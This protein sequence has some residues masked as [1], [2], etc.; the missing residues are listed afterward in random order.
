[1]SAV[2]SA[3]ASAVPSMV[4]EGAGNADARAI[5]W[6]ESLVFAA[7]LAALAALELVLLRAGAALSRPLWL[8]EIHTYL[9]AT[10]QTVIES[11]R[12]LAAGADY[13]PP[14]LY[15]LYR[16]VAMMA[17]GLTEVTMRLVALVSVL[18]ALGVTYGLLRTEYRRMPAVLAIVATWAHPVVVNVAFDARFYGPWLFGAAWLVVEAYRRLESTRSTDWWGA[19]R[20]AV[21]S[22]F[23]CTIHYFGVLSWGAVMIVAVTRG[24]FRRAL[25]AMAPAIAGPIALA[26]CLPLY[27]GQRGVLTVPTWIPDPSVG[28]VLFLL[29]VVLL[30]VATI[31]ALS[32][33]GLNVALL[34]ITK[35]RERGH[36]RWAAGLAS[37]L[38]MG[39]VI[40]P[41]TLAVFSLV[42]Q[43]AT[44]PRY[45]IVAALAVAPLLARAF[46][47]AGALAPLAGF[48][49][50]V[51]SV[52]AMKSEGD[53]AR[54]RAQVVAEDIEQIDRLTEPGS[55]IVTRRRH[56]LY[57]L[58]RARPALAARLAYLDATP[59]YP[60][61]RFAIVERDAARAH[62]RIY[63]F[64]RIESSVDLAA[65][66]AFYLIELDPSQ[67][68]T[69]SEFP[70]DSI[71]R[72][73]HRLFRL[74]RR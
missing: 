52:S 57:P 44:Q 60:G 53:V 35:K 12:S 50:L 27:R 32:A 65:R 14:A 42:V 71:A 34:R 30:P 58:L 2:E 72:V 17:G 48:A 55:L 51:C 64:P 59:A 29:G 66:D 69:P 67:A 49:A 19:A 4:R 31:I 5:P 18:A 26:C 7:G 28:D 9:L 3:A 54:L 22:V 62:T 40:V 13:N 46:S 70:R 68:P 47:R 1:M 37:Y 41:L 74:Q 11:L 56:T 10:D 8:D 38:L 61:D 33:W 21:V 43:P 45:W 39:Q 20:L 16:A 25:A 6:R 23:V 63:G 73:G 24:G 15:L 36:V